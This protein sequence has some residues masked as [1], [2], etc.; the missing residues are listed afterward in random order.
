[1]STTRVNI[2]LDDN[3]KEQATFVAKSLGLSLAGLMRMSLNEKLKS[4][5]L[6][7]NKILMDTAGDE[8]VSYSEFKSELKEMIANASD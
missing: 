4:N 8:L 2:T 3:L 7:I 5:D 6:V 1:M